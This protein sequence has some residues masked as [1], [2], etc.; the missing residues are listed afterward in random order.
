MEV[1]DR[2]G[3][4]LTWPVVGR[5]PSTVR[6]D[7]LD[8]GAGREADDPDLHPERLRRQAELQ[9]RHRGRVHELRLDQVP[10]G[11]PSGELRRKSTSPSADSMRTPTPR[12]PSAGATHPAGPAV[13]K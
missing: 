8:V 5:L 2:I 4:E 9:R 13:E 7:D 6:L 11:G 1:E 12:G 3:D 10:G